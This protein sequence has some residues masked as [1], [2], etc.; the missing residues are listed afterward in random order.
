MTSALCRALLLLAL[1]VPVTASYAQ[2]VDSFARSSPEAFLDELDAFLTAGR[3]ASA[4]ELSTDLRKRFPEYTA[5]QREAIMATTNAMVAQGM[6]VAPLFEDYLTAL[7]LVPA[8]TTAGGA[9]AEWHRALDAVL[10]TIENRRTA[11]FA[12]FLNF[13]RA[14]FRRGSLRDGSG[15]DWFARTPKYRITV[16]GGEPVVSFDTVRLVGQ[17]KS[18]SVTVAGTSGSYYPARN[19]FVGRGGRAYWDRV[20]LPDTYVTLRDYE[21]DVTSTLYEADSVTMVNPRYFGTERIVGRFADKISTGADES[22]GSYPRFTSHAVELELK[23]LGEGLTYF[24]GF[25]MH[26]TTVFGDAPAGAPA[27]I[28]LR[29][30]AGKLL[31]Q[32]VADAFVIRRGER[33]VG[34]QVRSTYYYGRDSIFHPS[35]S[36]RYD[37]PDRTLQL[38]RGD[39][40]ADRNPFYSSLQDVNFDVEELRI[41]VPQDSIVIG[42]GKLAIA[43]PSSRAELVSL[44]YFSAAD[45]NRYQNIATYN[46]LNVIKAVAEREGRDLDGASLAARI[47]PKF[48]IESVQTLY[49]DL[50]R[51]G[52]IDYDIDTKR[53]L[54]HDKLFHFVEAAQGKVDFDNLAIRS[55]TKEDNA[56][57]DIR[58]G[59]MLVNGVNNLELSRKQRVALVPVGGQVLVQGDRGVDFDGTLYAGF[60]ML[61][62]KDFHFEYAPYQIRLDSTRYFDVFVPQPVAP[63]EK[64]AE[65]LGIASRIEHVSGVLLIDAPNNKSGREDIAMFPSL[66]TDSP[67]FVY[68]DL[69]SNNDTAYRRDSF[70]FRL[71]EFSFNR[72]D[73]F[74]EADVRFEGEMQPGR[75]FPPYRADIYVRE[76]DRSLGHAFETA[77]EGW[78][79]YDAKGTFRGAVDLSNSGYYGRGTLNYLTATVASDSFLYLPEEMRASADAFDMVEDR[80]G[81]VKTPQA[82]GVD[83]AI[84]WFPFRD[85]M[86]VRS[87]EA[88][89]DLF[90]AG[91]HRLEGR[92][93]LTPSGLKGQG[94]HDWPQAT[95]SS[96]LINYAPFGAS[97]DTL[98]LAIKTSDGAGVALEAENLSGELDF[99]RDVGSFTANDTVLS[100]ALPSAQYATSMNEFDWDIAGEKITFGT[101]PGRLGSFVSTDP[102][103][104]SLFF[105]AATAGYDLTT[106]KLEV[107]GVPYVAAADALVY[108]SDGRLSIGTGGE[109]AELTGARIVADTVNKYHVIDSATVR[110]VGRKDYRAS[111]YYRYD[112]PGRAQRLYFADIIGERIGKGQRDQ[113][114]AVT[115]A[116]GEVTAD[117]R[118]FIDEAVRFQGAIGLDASRQELDFEGFAQLEAPGLPNPW[119]FSIRTL[120]NKD[121]LRL[122]YDVPRAP[123]G[124]DLHTGVF[125]SRETQ[126]AYPLLF[127]PTHTGMDRS[128]LDMSSG[129]FDH[130]RGTREFVFGDSL[131]VIGATDRGRLAT[132]DG[133]RGTFRGSGRL[134]LGSQLDYISMKSAGTVATAFAKTDDGRTT[135][136]GLEVDALLSIDFIIPEKLINLVVADIQAS[137]F[138]APDV[139][140]GPM[141]TFLRP[142]LLNWTD[143]PQDTSAIGAARGGAFVLPKGEPDHSFVFPR[144]NLTYNGEYESFFS[145]GDRLD[146]AYANGLPVHKRLEGYLEVKMPGSGDDRLYLYLKTPGQTWYFFGYKQGILNVASS[147]ARFLESLEGLKAR[148]LTQK[149]PDGELY[150]VAPVNAGTANSF[151]ARVREARGGN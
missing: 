91:D 125:L 81:A 15:V 19:T 69:P 132:V 95:L 92:L 31:F 145:T 40:A 80:A 79:T 68:Y 37:I 119:W 137:G 46:P 16:E 134:D 17:R 102:E 44:Q 129:L 13:S 67:A 50:V 49:F 141:A 110:L 103:R 56:T 11:G 148:E 58:S 86:Y 72:L 150:E 120:G 96:T 113:K 139:A 48:T 87:E 84:D 54:V 115:R 22:T 121:D 66:Q 117:E 105:R 47:D 35:V 7:A 28:E 1:L 98:F 14:F 12:A 104:D 108:P 26:G 71:D 114:S 93:I 118:F 78:P 53:V 62:G 63:G 142:A 94:T 140:Y 77:L 97:S 29:N 8:D 89:F 100:V 127:M 82:R 88:P 33:V 36:A 38:M 61:E 111:G 133:E 73:G 24:G 124:D 5:G 128:I 151:V 21:V 99:D 55:D 23:D 39:R 85:S 112:L 51:D 65:P 27:R 57:F 52:F 138:D 43:K 123:E 59:E 146:L 131:R 70:Y 25:R 42:P 41:Y 6:P 64:P 60:T 30:E 83:V 109:I 122:P 3:R 116:S 76:A 107:G 147:S 10:A 126:Q 136:T 75:I 4:A 144:V 130:K 2:R 20:G 45:Y 90:A 18:D 34:Q 32:G 106:A 9:F 143:A 101:V 149:M 74:A 135:G